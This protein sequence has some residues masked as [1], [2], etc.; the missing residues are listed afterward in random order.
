M[1]AMTESDRKPSGPAA[2]AFLS[3][4]VGSLALGVFTFLA[5][6]VKSIAK[7]LNWY[8][9]AGPLSGKTG[10]A[11]LVWLVLWAILGKAWQG[12]DVELGRI[13]TVTIVLIAIGFLLTFP[14]V[15]QMRF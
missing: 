2:A 11:I 4:G 9:P 8:N 14:V 1:A 10:L 13:Y 3:V 6:N 15:F 5:E 12:K 7:A